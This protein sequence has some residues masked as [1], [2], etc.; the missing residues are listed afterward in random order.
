MNVSHRILIV[1]DDDAL[2]QSLAEQLERDAEFSVTECGTA[3]MARDAVSRERF[4]AMLLDVG[5]PDM[6]GR[7]LCREFRRSAIHVPIVMLT[8]ADSEGDTVQGLDAGADDYVTKPFLLRELLARVRA[9]LRRSHIDGAPQ[10]RFL[11]AGELEVD[12][13]SRL[14]RKNGQEIHLSPKEFELLALLMRHP[15]VPFTHSRLLR[16]VWGAEYGGELEYLRT[17]VKFLR[18]KIEADPATPAYILTEPWVGYRFRDP[19]DA[20]ST[21]A[22]LAENGT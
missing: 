1:D 3:T 7:D 6:D 10:A 12:L 13:D 11:R 17:Y 21:S 20:D 5:L 19:A 16:G 22:R 4:D 9:I 2:R 14:L 18:K 8:A 15:G